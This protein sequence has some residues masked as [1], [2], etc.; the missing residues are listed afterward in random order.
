M[1]Q[2]KTPITELDFDGIKTQLKQYLQT[3]TQFKDYNFEGSNMSI[4]LDVLAY[5]TYHNNFYTNM[6]IN[7]MFLDSAQLRNSI[8]SHSKELNYLPRSRKS[9]K[10]VIKC[11]ITSNDPTFTDQTI[12]IPTYT[13]FTSNYNGEVFNF[14]TNETYVARKIGNGV[15]ETD[16]MEIFEGTMLSSFEREG[17]IVDDDGSLRV[18][19]SNPEVDTDSIVVFVD[20]EQTE[21]NNI[22]S[23]A[24]S[25]FGVEP[26]SKVYYIEP[27]FDDKYSIYFGRDI[28]GEQPLETQD[29]RVRYR[30]CSGTTPNGASSFNG[31]FIENATINVTTIQE[32]IGGSERESNESI[33]FNAPKSIQIQERAITT[34]DYEV[35][36]KQRFPEIA[37]V[38]AYSGDELEPP[39]FGKVAIAVFLKGNNNLI[40]STLS[41][42]YIDFLSDKTPLGIEP[43]F[44]ETEFLYVDLTVNVFATAKLSNM[45]KDQLESLVRDAVSN[46]SSTN[47]EEF[48]K[49]LR[50]SKLS[51]EIDEIDTGV[52]S[53]SIAALPIIEYSPPLEIF[54]NPTF[55]FDTPLVRPYPFDESQGFS[56]YKP[57]I[58]SSVFGVDGVCVYI[59]DDGLGNIQLVTDDLTN[60][61]VIN[62]TAGTIDY[63]TGVVKL[64]NFKVES[65]AGSAI[66]IKART[67]NNDIKAPK[68][69]VFIIR[70]DDLVVNINIE[71][72]TNS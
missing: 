61:Q 11:R 59:Q 52:Q 64:V 63:T 5:N 53:N 38:S 24:T 14:V 58:R 15:Y 69:R 68:G 33:R 56:D 71:D 72:T 26:D 18:A 20:A 47:L 70:D 10:A 57:A 17:Y 2:P 51:A 42:S 21:D 36:L 9:A 44:I 32:A 62:P 50:L 37:A 34:N 67:V 7:E 49:T 66:K 39:Q 29:V 54:T 45:S 1:A 16:E 13:E 30:V 27:Y 12:V 65:F 31:N 23:L 55:K 48:N 25:I 40:S 43:T 19:L 35:L 3:Q 6:A 28:Y 8:V 22:Y 41:N 60:P 4:L 46:H